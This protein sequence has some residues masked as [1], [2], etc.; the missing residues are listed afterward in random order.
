MIAAGLGGLVGAGPTL[1]LFTLRM[2]R[3]TGVT[4]DRRDQFVRTS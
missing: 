3:A 4:F 2:E 1:R